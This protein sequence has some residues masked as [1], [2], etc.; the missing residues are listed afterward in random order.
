VER[1]STRGKGRR[2]AVVLRLNFAI[3]DM[4]LITHLE[5]SAGLLSVFEGDEAVA[6][7]PLLIREPTVRHGEEL[8]VQ[9]RL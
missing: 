1:A 9:V 5:G 7:L 4:K 2:R 3:N 8:L 6:R